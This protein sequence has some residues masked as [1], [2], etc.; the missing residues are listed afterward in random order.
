MHARIA[1][2]NYTKTLRIF[3]IL[4]L[5]CVVYVSRKVYHIRMIQSSS[6]VLSV[7][8]YI[9]IGIL[10]IRTFWC[11]SRKVLIESSIFH[12]FFFHFWVHCFFFWVAINI[13]LLHVLK[14]RIC[15]DYAC[16]IK[17]LEN[18]FQNEVLQW[19]LNCQSMKVCYKIIPLTFFFTEKVVIG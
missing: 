15:L 10:Y 11:I 13:C 9:K 16:Q 5:F 7:T 19:L 8:Q 3:N 4:N 14:F 6:L 18:E 2:I 1:Y 17:E 12:Q